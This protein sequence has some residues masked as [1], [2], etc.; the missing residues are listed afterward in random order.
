M[1]NWY[2]SLAALKARAN[3]TRTDLDVQLGQI[4][5]NVSRQ[6]DFHC[7]HQFFVSTRT[8]YYTYRCQPDRDYDLKV[9]D[10]LAVTTLKTDLAGLRTYGQTWTAGV[11]YE[12]G[13]S[14]APQEST[15]APYWQVNRIWN[16]SLFFPETTRGVQ[17]VGKGGYY[18]VLS[19]SSATLAE[20]LDTSET[21]IDVS[22]GTVFE[23]GQTLL[24]GSEQLFITSINLATT[25]DAI[26]V[27]P[28]VGL[29]GTTPAVHLTG[30][31]I[32]VY[33][34]PVVSESC[35]TQAQRR[36]ERA[37]GRPSRSDSDPSLRAYASLD[38]DVQDAL[39]EL[40]R[41]A[42]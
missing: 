25:P 33:T 35:L 9:N 34:Y 10:L 19:R 30:A 22:D 21:V 28:R 37:I 8:W 1:S 11:D 15:P 42:I 4:L 7:N 6:I 14:D 29:N 41:T 5:D 23:V 31:A 12:L 40:R 2:S 17:I 39:E 16:S 13:P 27:A 24:I 38:R 18:E 26:T 3:I 32:D 36:F 20:D